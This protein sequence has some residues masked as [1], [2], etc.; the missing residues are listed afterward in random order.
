ML[1]LAARTEQSALQRSEL[2][3]TRKEFEGGRGRGA[4]SPGRAKKCGRRRRFLV[5]AGR[6]W[7]EHPC[8]TL[9]RTSSMRQRVGNVIHDASSPSRI[10]AA[11]ASQK[12]SSGRCLRGPRTDPCT[13]EW[14]IHVPGQM[15]SACLAF[16][17]NLKHQRAI[18]APTWHPLPAVRS[19][20]RGLWK[21]GVRVRGQENSSG[22]DGETPWRRIDGKPR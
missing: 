4:G 13:A 20:A 5:D 7:S 2:A 6:V 1:I 8:R 15:L 11:S 19:D 22:D 14:D 9:R 3:Q 16:I 18:L 10:Q 21:L 12:T 17:R